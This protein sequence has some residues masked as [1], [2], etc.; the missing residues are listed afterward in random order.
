MRLTILALLLAPAMAF[1]PAV[2][3]AKT[4][5]KLDMQ[6]RDVLI[7]GI[8]GLVAAPTLAQASGSST[9]FYD[10]KI[11]QV[12]EPTQMATDGR[13]D[14]NSAYVVSLESTENSN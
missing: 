6:R 10:E 13:L 1:V 9:W 8:M 11:E 12:V 3:K 7:T 4:T 14:L 2:Q 5:T